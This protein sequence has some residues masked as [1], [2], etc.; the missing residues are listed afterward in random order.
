MT[1]RDRRQASFDHQN[2]SSY[3]GKFVSA[4]VV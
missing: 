2:D 4:L 1:L 3:I